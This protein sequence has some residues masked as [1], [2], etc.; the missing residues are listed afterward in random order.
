MWYVS[1]F[2]RGGIWDWTDV[3]ELGGELAGESDRG[4]DCEGW[5]SELVYLFNVVDWMNVTLRIATGCTT[6]N[7]TQELHDETHILPIK[8][9]LQLHYTVLIV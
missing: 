1:V 5:T 3:G 2:C 7:N 4:E 9:H 6:D 8:E